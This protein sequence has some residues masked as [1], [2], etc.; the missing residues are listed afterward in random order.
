MNTRHDR[1]DEAIDQVAARLTKVAD[2][3]GFA[4]RIVDILPERSAWS[5]RWLMPR[6]AMTAA[7]GIGVALVVLRS[8]DGRSTG[9]LLTQNP[10]APFVEFRAVVERTAVEPTQIGR[11][12]TVE[13]SQ[14]VRRTS[15]DFDRSLE[16]IA[17]PAPLSLKVVSPSD[18]PRQGSLAVEPLAIADL[19]LT[20]ETISPR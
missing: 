16:A 4:L 2:D 15:E 8:F 20:A 10:G 13:R 14:T 12:T 9:V 19:P 1:L 3:E 17:A 11:R 7:I 18:L 5:L 6:L